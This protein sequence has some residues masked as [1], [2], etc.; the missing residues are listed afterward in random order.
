MGYRSEPEIQ[1]GQSVITLAS[2]VILLGL[3]LSAILGVALK[4]AAREPVNFFVGTFG[5]V[6]SIGGFGLTLWQLSLTQTAAQSA[7]GAV[8]KLRKDVKALDIISEIHVVTTNVATAIGF[9]RARNWP[10]ASASYEKIRLSL[11]KITVLQSRL[12]AAFDD[13][14]AKDFLSH[15][16]ATAGA[17]ELL[18]DQDD[19]DTSDMRAKLR[20]L[21]DYT[22]AIEAHIRDEIGEQ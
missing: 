10:D 9:L 22:V 14:I 7:S 2:V 13:G 5:L 15:L 3:V 18:A 12:G 8:E 16:I 6:L 21:N 17:L 4:A 1:S 11:N 19:I 20:E